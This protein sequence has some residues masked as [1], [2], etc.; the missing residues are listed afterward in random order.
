MAS[1]LLQ[2]LPLMPGIPSTLH[3][4]NKRQNHEPHYARQHGASTQPVTAA[5]SSGSCAVA[6]V[7]AAATPSGGGGRMASTMGRQ[8]QQQVHTVSPPM[9]SDVV[10]TS[11]PFGPQG[12]TAVQQQLSPPQ[13]AVD[14]FQGL[15]PLT[16]VGGPVGTNSMM[17]WPS[18]G[19]GDLLG[20]RVSSGGS[21]DR[22]NGGG[23]AMAFNPLWPEAVPFG[24]DSGIEG[25]GQGPDLLMPFD[26]ADMGAGG[27]FGFDAASDDENGSSQV[28]VMPISAC[29][30]V[31]AVL[32]SCLFDTPLSICSH[33]RTLTLWQR[34]SPSVPSVELMGVRL[35]RA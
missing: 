24:S 29:S 31:D 34:A 30:H 21:R 23:A 28:S 5:M 27:A 20:L 4:T 6:A 14:H 25:S 8:Q 22:S 16:A 15:V 18:H 7:A 12:S 1:A 19:G 35:P 33:L 10:K 32:V 11:E 13:G 2:S 9:G 17:P 3:G 26:A